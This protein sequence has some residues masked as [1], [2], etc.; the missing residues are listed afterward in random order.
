MNMNVK[1]TFFRRDSCIY[2]AHARRV[3]EYIMH[4]RQQPYNI[5]RKE[6]MHKENKIQAGYVWRG[7]QHFTRKFIG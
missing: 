5:E 7:W 1:I 2:H 3:G 6:E 4:I